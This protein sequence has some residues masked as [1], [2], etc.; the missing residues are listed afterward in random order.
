M[1]EISQKRQG[2]IGVL[3]RWIKHRPVLL[4]TLLVV[5]A[6]IMLLHAAIVAWFVAHSGPPSPRVIPA[7]SVNPPVPNP[8]ASG[9]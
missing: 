1:V 4:M 8:D 7:S 9:S 6:F 3:V 2:P 5:L